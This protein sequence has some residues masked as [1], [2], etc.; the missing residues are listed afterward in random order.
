MTGVDAWRIEM[1]GNAGNPGRG[2]VG[3]KFGK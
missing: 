1:A 2:E 3:G